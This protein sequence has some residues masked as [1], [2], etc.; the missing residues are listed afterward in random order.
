MRLRIPNS[1]E[2]P[3]FAIW[4]LLF[5]AG[6]AF[7]TVIETVAQIPPILPDDEV[8]SDRMHLVPTD[9]LGFTGYR[10]VKRTTGPAKDGETAPYVFHLLLIFEKDLPFDCCTI[11]MGN[12][13]F[14]GSKIGPRTASLVI[15]KEKLQNGLP[16]AVSRYRKYEREDRIVL[17]DK[18]SVPKEYAMTEAE[19]E[20]EV[21]PRCRPVVCPSIAWQPISRHDQAQRYRVCFR[22]RL[23]GRV[24]AK[25]RV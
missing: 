5:V 9:P 10:L 16:L 13:W 21:F 7:L 20:A 11:W 1:A 23:V 12:H 8:I 22:C 3:R 24:H 17:G 4:A 2:F 6:L 19:I 15:R 14:L 18:V 25:H